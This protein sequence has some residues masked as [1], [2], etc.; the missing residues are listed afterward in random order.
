M[1]KYTDI[2]NIFYSLIEKDEDFFNY[3]EVPMSEAMEIAEERAAKYLEEAVRIVQLECMPQIDFNKRVD[4]ENIKG[5]GF[6]FS[7]SELI[8]IPSLMYEQ[9]LFRDFSY[10]KTRSENFTSSEI[11]VFD[12]SN[13]RTSFN[14]MYRIVQ[15]KNEKLK[16]TYKNTDRLTGGYRVFD[17]A[18]YD[19]EV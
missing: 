4:T 9:Y 11:R 19:I 18:K 12:P 3:Y 5:F 10:L 17:V 6:D 8:L 13:A 7:P 15:E 14:A 16:D 1:T 2:Y